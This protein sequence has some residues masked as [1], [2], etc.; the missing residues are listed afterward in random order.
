MAGQPRS[1]LLSMIGSSSGPISRL[2]SGASVW[3]PIT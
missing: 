2:K 1:T 3:M